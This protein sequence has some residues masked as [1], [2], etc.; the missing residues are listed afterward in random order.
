MIQDEI[1]SICGNFKNIRRIL[2]DE[3]H[4]M[5]ALK[6]EMKASKEPSTQLEFKN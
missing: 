5:L 6:D 2:I 1:L 4:L 3:T